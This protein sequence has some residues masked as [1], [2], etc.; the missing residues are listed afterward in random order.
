MTVDAEVTK[1]AED[2]ARQA[3]EAAVLL[4]RRDLADH[5]AQYHS[6]APTPPGPIPP[7]PTPG[8]I[9]PNSP[10]VL[11]PPF[12]SA[13][14]H[15]VWRFAP[16]PTGARG[17]AAAPG[18]NVFDGPARQNSEQAYFDPDQAEVILTAG[19]PVLRFTA[20]NQPQ[21]GMP[22]TSAMMENTNFRIGSGKGFAVL[23]RQRWEDYWG[24]WV[25][26]WLYNTANQNEIDLCESVNL[27]GPTFN[28]HI[29][30]NGPETGTKSTRP[31]A[32]FDVWQFHDYWTVVLP[33]DRDGVAAG[34]YSTVDGETRSYDGP[35]WA[36][37]IVNGNMWPKWQHSVLGWWPI[38][39]GNRNGKNV[40]EEIKNELAT[41]RYNELAQYVAF[42]L[43]A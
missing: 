1:I 11:P 31:T 30:Q 10:I 7:Q 5:V 17:A 33:L 24:C 12:T 37:Q 2:Q 23:C 29:T 22:Y 14:S 27:I 38:D 6:G 21:G 19:V 20:I 4:S 25:G 8:P 40:V 16:G 36:Q 43:A 15:L 32:N 28:V 34:I 13:N 3:G 35:W 26:P 41:P 9:L 39:D 18:W 42:E